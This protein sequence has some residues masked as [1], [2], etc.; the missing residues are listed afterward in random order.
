[1][2]NIINCETFKDDESF[3]RLHL[4][5]KIS[6]DDIETICK[7]L[8]DRDQD[9]TLCTKDWEIEITT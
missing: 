9:V 6:E 1:M 3:E 8:K 2:G 4:K 7:S 5:I